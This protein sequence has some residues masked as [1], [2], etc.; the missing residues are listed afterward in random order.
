MIIVRLSSA[1][2]DNA[3]IWGGMSGSPVYADDGRLIGAVSYGLTWEASP[4]GG[5]T[6]AGKMKALLGGGGSSATAKALATTQHV[7]LPQRIQQRL[8]SDG[9][10]TQT[11]AQ[12]GMTRLPLPLGVSG[13]VSVARLKKAESRLSG[14][15]LLDRP[16][17]LVYKSGAA[18]TAAAGSDEISAGSN[19]AATI[20]YGDFTAGGIGTTTMVCNDTQVVGFGHP[21]DWTGDST[22]TMNG[23]DVI[24]VLKDNIGGSYKLSN[25]T[26]PV[27]GI[28][29][30]HLTGISGP[31]GEDGIP[32]TALIRSNV[33]LVSTG[34]SRTGTTYTS[35]PNYLPEVALFAEESNQDVI[36]DR[37]G[38]GSS[39]VRFLV[40][41]TADGQEFTLM[42]AN[43]FANSYDISFE[44]IFEVVRRCVRSRYPSRQWP[45]RL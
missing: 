18:P 29:G 25:I 8:V 31:V 11:E 43:R 28:T 22:L 17:V 40:T 16:D 21:F 30:D 19:L 4:V 6:P 2:I 33:T 24:T 12:A 35:V 32:A 41:G 13:S 45:S 1:V 10:A 27:G 37:V 15:S 34:K 20:S 5:L 36:F 44:S 7:A 38:A 14:A 42:R 9:L 3:G 26:G 23:A 39:L